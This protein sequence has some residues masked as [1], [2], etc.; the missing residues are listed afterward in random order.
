MNQK[1]DLVSLI[2][3][4]QTVISVTLFFIVFFFCWH[5]TDLEITKIQVSFWGGKDMKYGWLWN[6]IIILLSLS[7][8]FNNIFFIK[9][10]NRIIYKNFLYVIFSFTSICLFFVGVFS[11]EHTLLHGI[12]AWLYFFIY[13]L[14]VFLLSHLN[15][16]SINY[17]EWLTHLVFSISMIVLP[18]IFINFFEGY[19][20]SEIIHSILVCS[21]NIYIS[22]KIND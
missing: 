4:T 14:N 12:P 13:P 17:N 15:R 18:L 3:K 2:R 22:F 8:F 7:L 10:H 19:A 5:I 16:K 21:W 11:L 9:K 1:S 6:S 20:I